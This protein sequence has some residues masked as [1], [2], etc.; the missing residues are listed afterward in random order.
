MIEEGE[1]KADK[2]REGGGPS[3][4][5]SSLPPW[6]Q[7]LLIPIVQVRKLRLEPGGQS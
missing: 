2:E 7:V 1:G 6:K 5:E 4:V 3:F